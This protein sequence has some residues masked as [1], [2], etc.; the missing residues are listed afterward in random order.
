MGYSLSVLAV[1]C[2]DPDVA[3]SRLNI[4]RTGQTCEYACE[5][6]TGHAMPQGWYLVVANCCDHR[7]LQAKV[8]GPLSQNYRVV[9]CSIEEHVMFSSAEEWVAGAMAWR[10]VHAGENGPIDLKTSGALPPSFQSMANALAA[11][12]EAEDGKTA[13]V[14]HYFD[15]PLNAAKAITGFK[16]DEKVPGLDYEKFDLLQDQ[17][18]LQRRVDELPIPEIPEKEVPRWVQV[19][20]GLVLA[21]LTLLCGFASATM[22]VVPN[23]KSPILTI[24]VGLILLL[25]CLW[26][27]EKCFRLL[28]GRKNRG[29]LMAPNTLRVVSFFFLAPPV[30]GLFTGYYRK[31]GPVAI[32]EA[33]MYFFSF[34]GLRVLARKR[35]A[36]GASNVQTKV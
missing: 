13:E 17:K 36:T 29:G 31:M 8:L 4:V 34:L 30:A 26:V 6:L 10:A 18:P 28:T 2:S 25:G 33:V 23:E 22:L 1:Q 16:H 19:L 11:K 24:I 32:F 20:V 3:L 14:D 27:F 12:Q 5:Q 35:E 15:I 21:L 7:F 9:A